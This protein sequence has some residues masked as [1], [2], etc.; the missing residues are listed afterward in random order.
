MNSTLSISKLND[1]CTLINTKTNQLMSN[2]YTNQRLKLSTLPKQNTILLVKL[3]KKQRPVPV[4]LQTQT[5]YTK[6]QENGTRDNSIKKNRV[7]EKQNPQ[8]LSHPLFPFFHKKQSINSIFTYKSQLKTFTE[9]PIH[10]KLIFISLSTIIISSKWV[11]M[12]QLYR[13]TGQARQR[14]PNWTTYRSLV[15]LLY[16]PTWT[17][18]RLLSWPVLIGLSELHHRRISSGFPNC[19]RLILIF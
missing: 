18:R 12:L 8:D 4:Q 3:E 15:Q 13:T 17:R 10:T 11:L 2:L 16:C 7:H 6:L 19:P 14:G 5:Q 9:R 1:I